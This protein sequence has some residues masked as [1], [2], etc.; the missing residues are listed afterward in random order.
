M[1]LKSNP[2]DLSRFPEENPHPVLQAGLDG[3]CLYGNPAAEKIFGGARV[4]LGQPLPA[5]LARLVR[6]AARTGKVA[7]EE[8]EQ[9]GRVFHFSAVTGRKRGYVNIYGLDITER[10]ETRKSLDR[11][12]AL[13]SSVMRTTDVMLVFLDREFN[14]LWVNQ[15]YAGTCR[16]K[17]REMIG[18]NHFALYPDPENEAI[19]RRV[20]DT[21]R[22]VFYKDKPFVFPNQPERGTTY[23][24]WSLSPVKDKSGRVVSLVFSL[25]E[26]TKYQRARLA[27]AESE[28]RYRLLFDHMIEGFALHEIILDKAGR[29]RDYRFL[30]VNRAF[31]K[32]TGVSR[33]RL[34]GRTV[35]EVLPETETYWIEQFGKVALTGRPLHYEN[36][37][38]ALGK[39]YETFAYSTGNKR[40]AVVF[41]NITKRKLSE[42]ALLRNERRLRLAQAASGAG[43]WDWDC[44]SDQLNWSDELFGIFGLTPG[45]DRA[46]FETWR[47]IIH[48]EDREIAEKRISEAV[49][50]RNPL[51][52][53]YRIVLSSGAIRW[54]RAL[55]N[56]VPEREGEHRRMLGI[57]LDVTARKNLENLLQARL[58]EL[59]TVL[60][61]APV[62]IFYKDKANRFLRVNRAFQEAMNL[63][64]AELEGSSMSDLFPRKQAEAYGKDD[65]EVITSGR[66]KRGIIETMVTSRGTRIVQTDKIPYFDENGEIKGVIGFAV[67]I[68]DIKQS[69]EA[70]RHSGELLSKAQQMAHLG[71]WE[72]DLVANQLS[73][74]DE[75]YRIFGLKPGEFKSSYEAF[76]K[77]VHPEDRQEVDDAYSASIREGKNSYEIEHRVIRK[78]TGEVRIVH[79][80]CTHTRDSSGKVIR[81]VG[82]VHDITKRKSAEDALRQERQ[83]LRAILDSMDDL[84]YITG[85][86]CEIEYINPAM[87]RAFGPIGGKKCHNY[88]HRREKPCPE[89]HQEEVTGGR[90]VRFEWE[91]TKAGKNYDIIESPVPNPDG[92]ISKLKIMRDITE[93]KKL[94][95][96]LRQFN[97]KLE[98]TVIRRTV[99]LNDVKEVLEKIFAS[100][101]FQL[102]YLDADF[103]FLRVNCAY[104]E[105]SGRKPGYFIGRNHF[106]LVPNPENERIFRRVAETGRAF[107]AYARPFVYPGKSGNRTTYCDWSLRPVRDAKGAVDGFLLILV[108]VTE[109]KESRE[110]LNRA[111]KKMADMQRLAELGTLA[112]MVA[113]EMRTPLATVRLAAD[114]LARKTG[115][116]NLTRHIRV[117]A[118]KIEVA[119]QIITNLLD[120][121]RLNVPRY[122]LFSI[123]P[124]IRECAAVSRKAHS[125]KKVSI[126][127]ELAPLARKRVSA[128]RDQVR[129]AL[130]NILDNALDACP[131]EE[132]KLEI[133]GRIEKGNQLV[134]RFRDNGPGFSEEGLREA[135]T[136]FYTSKAS[137][138]GLGLAISRDL[139]H[140]H[141]G[142]IEA[143]N[144]AG[145]GALIT[146]KLPLRDPHP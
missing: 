21:G 103:N 8:I 7:S 4:L 37:S 141:N 65:Q 49:S 146:L 22:R 134:L 11:E 23:W 72:L 109:E 17:P 16:M 70:L 33:K 86:D 59:E 12:R 123:I 121:S 125:R 89:C 118:G 60:D 96:S 137:G 52:S 5:G 44:D 138:T 87:E 73:W 64:R 29:P 63:S 50:S 107:I 26:T 122:R 129:Q 51:D 88:L 111:Q 18:K 135:F 81:S 98:E 9:Q 20:R 80:K 28:E 13:L 42:E 35:R 10:E 34:I 133:I 82:M 110:K 83:K 104:A 127:T 78:N 2:E 71:S 62:L 90:K 92:T 119:N 67:D 57:C 54:I 48:P 84:I 124:L 142:S 112:S 143:E 30:E 14:F 45:K 79:E 99:D 97:E 113:H 32:L 128:D 61:A 3:T 19:F 130:N 95:K 58:T 55:G 139:V 31:E 53:E 76:L 115:D 140:L 36:Y 91:A 93:L 25:R 105:A 126:R 24:D 41:N 15:A 1:D 27:L 101:H 74:S 116:P 94:E 117:I 56:T 38:S 46:D 114:N 136:P 43:V 40:F 68:T 132:G 145:G 131:E 102:A 77:R 144:A 47:K 66:A 75:T 120:Y 100:V 85:A 39:W 108:D 106:D 69:E 6:R